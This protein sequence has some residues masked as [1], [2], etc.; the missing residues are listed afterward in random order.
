MPCTENIT[1]EEYADFIVRYYSFSALTFSQEIP[2]C[3]SYVSNQYAVT[4]WK[5]ASIPPISMTRY[6]YYTIPKLYTLLDTTSMEASGIIRTFEQPTLNYKGRGTI[7]GIIDTGIDYRNPLF[8]NSDGTS[9][10]LGIWDQTIPGPGLT[11]ANPIENLHFGT[12]YTREEIN[13]ALRSDNPLDVVPT[14]DDNGHGTFLAKIAAGNEDPA[15]DFTGAAPECNLVI[16]KL[17]PAKQ[18]LRDYYM[19]PDSAIAYQESDIMLGI[20]YL[21]YSAG[22]YLMP[23]TILLGLGTNQGSHDGSSPLATYLSSVST[24]PGIIVVVAAGNETGSSH[25]YFGVIPSTQEFE[26]V[27]MNVAPGETGFTIE[28]WARE[29]ELYS[30][31]FISPT[32]EQ[33]ARVPNTTSDEYRLTFLLEKTVIY[34]N[35]RVAESGTGS[36]LIMM[37]FQNPTQGIWR[38]RIYNA[39]YVRGE[40]H[41]W[42]PTR[43]FVAEDTVFLRAN[44]DTTITEPGNAP[45]LMTIAGYNHRDN[46]LY[47]RSSRGYTRQNAVKPDLTAPAVDITVPASPGER[48]TLSGTSVAAAHAAGAAAVL[49]SWAFTGTNDLYMNTSTAKAFLVRGA[50]RNPIFTYPNREWGYGTLDLYNSFIQLRG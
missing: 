4:H 38:M 50:R 15:Q 7:I 29:P 35:Y 26:D 33:I 12:V 31:S 49:L 8:R 22:Q 43:G 27:E 19:V 30:I 10:I 40:Y 13:Q 1:S 16:V 39:L 36:Q 21:L 45:L 2:S 44:P 20:K 37:R 47:I 18:Y 11:G 25:H 28:L 46:S 41:M 34:L 24:S 14:D 23:A 32:G 6:P 3:V 48:R 17:K 9:R 5:L 42:L